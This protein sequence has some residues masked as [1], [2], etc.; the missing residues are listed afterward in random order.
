MLNAFLHALSAVLVPAF[1]FGMAGSAVVVLV[2][3]FRDVRDFRSEDDPA[4]TSQDG[5]NQ[6]APQS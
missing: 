6:A 2:T 4:E 5:L 1:L 3:L